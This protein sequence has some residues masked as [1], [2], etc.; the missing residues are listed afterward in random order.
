MS[1]FAPVK[2]QMDLI[3]RGTEEVIPIEELENKIHD[4]L[5]DELSTKAL[6]LFNVGE[7]YG[8]APLFG[9][10]GLAALGHGKATHN[11]I[12]KAIESII[13]WIENDLINEMN[14]EIEKL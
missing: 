2:E 9:V 7:T 4:S 1:N 11:T 5:L 8:A 14:K 3:L 10:N 6:N 13:M 12:I